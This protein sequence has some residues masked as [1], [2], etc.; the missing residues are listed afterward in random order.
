MGV[1]PQCVEGLR[2]NILGEGRG[3]VFEKFFTRLRK[4]DLEERF[5]LL[6]IQRTAF[7]YQKHGGCDLRRGYERFGFYL[8]AERRP[9]YALC[10]Y[11]ERGKRFLS[12]LCRELDGHFLLNHNQHGAALFILEGFQYDIGCN[13]VGE[14]RY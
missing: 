2:H 4:S 7:F 6:V 3:E 12:G 14:V 8:E 13:I 5:E 10:Q 11:G 9:A 1:K